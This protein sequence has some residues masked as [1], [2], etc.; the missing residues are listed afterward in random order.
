MPF[1]WRSKAG[2]FDIS[3]YRICIY[4]YIYVCMYIYMYVYIY[5]MYNYRRRLRRQTSDN[6]DR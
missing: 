6:M 3:M 1:E 4:N 2:L 5:N